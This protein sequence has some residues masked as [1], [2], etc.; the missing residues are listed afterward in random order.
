MEIISLIV[1]GL[2]LIETSFLAYRSFKK[3]FNYFGQKRKIY[4]DSSALM[5]GRVLKVV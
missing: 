4:V 1:H 5:D 2:I 3:S